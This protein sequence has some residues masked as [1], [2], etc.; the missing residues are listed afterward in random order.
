MGCGV[1]ILQAPVALPAACAPVSGWRRLAADAVVVGGST[2]VCHALGAAASL[3]LRAALPPAQLGVWHGLRVLLDHS[4][5]ASLG[6][7]KAAMRELSIAEGRG[8]ASAAQPILDLAYTFNSVTCLAYAAVLAVAAWWQV[9]AAGW[10]PWGLGLLAVA[11][12][13]LLQRNATFRVAVLRSR[14][15]F[16]AVSRL[17]VLEAGLT[18]SLACMGAWLWGLP[19]LYAG[20][21]IVMATILAIVCRQCPTRFAWC[22][23]MKGF[24]R[25]IGV[26]GP[27][28]L[29]SLAASLFA[30][31]DKLMLLGYLDEGAH[32]LGC[33]SAALLVAAQLNGLGNVLAVTTAPRLAELWGKTSSRRDVARL[34]A[35]VTE[36]LAAGIALPAGLAIVA[37]PP[38]LAWLLPDYRTGLPAIAWL[39]P[40]TVA[41][42]LAL[43]AGQ[44]LV[45]VDGGRRILAALGVGLA[46]AAAGNHLA[47]TRGLGLEGVAASMAAAN[48]L[49]LLTMAW[50]SLWPQLTSAE[51]GRSAAAVVLS[52]FPTLAVALAAAAALGGG[53][54]GLAGAIGGSAAVVAVWGVTTGLQWRFGGWHDLA[55]RR[56]AR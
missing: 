51:R 56:R 48:G 21:A 36:V 3:L 30:S 32:H 18:L 20:T 53:R 33:Y 11:G 16:G 1:S 43:P 17:T 52:V 26:G 35:R 8:D 49:T 4:S 40:G 14:Q 12:L 38:A 47:L 6:A 31:L 22:W 24:G 25:L 39:V 50:L 15:V 13:A 45:A 44:Y 37:A 46:A 54:I 9:W 34:A 27:L 29:A 55:L 23:D 5:Y 7:S 28:L 42:V 19:G 41:G 10:Q 2:V